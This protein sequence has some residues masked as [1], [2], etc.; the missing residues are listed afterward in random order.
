M[1]CRITITLL[2]AALLALPG[3]APAQEEVTSG[4]YK[5]R[6][7]EVSQGA[8]EDYEVRP[9][10]GSPVI[11]DDVYRPGSPYG[12]GASQSVM[13]RRML[14][15]SHWNL[16]NYRF[17]R[18]DDSGCHPGR[19]TNLHTVR[20]NISCRQCHGGEPISSIQHYYSS[21]NPIRRH[22]YICAKCHEGPSASFA[23]YLI[24]EPN[25]AAASTLN[26]FPALAWA[27]W[28]MIGIAITTFALFLPH[29][30]LWGLR[31][32]LAGNGKSENTVEVEKTETTKDDKA[33]GGE[34][35]D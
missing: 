6:D 9:G 26:T 32:L 11:M 5:Y 16:P 27:F 23:T 21:M 12:P 34:D 17:R 10:R 31:E 8:Y 29:T 4:T 15:D 22:A 18:C 35:D 3:P 7:S 2:L 30:A 28:I 33:E 25:P 13:N 19:E 14:E 1:A 20:M 24:H